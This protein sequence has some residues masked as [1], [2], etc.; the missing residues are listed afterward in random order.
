M[1][2]HGVSPMYSITGYGWDVMDG[3][4]DVSWPGPTGSIPGFE[5]DSMICI[6]R[7]PKSST[8][9]PVNL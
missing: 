1:E 8:F 6:F 3:G 5:G 7:C 2:F 4:D 9:Q